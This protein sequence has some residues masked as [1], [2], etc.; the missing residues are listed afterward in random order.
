MYFL[1]AIIIF[2]TFWSCRQE[3]QLIDNNSKTKNVSFTH[4]K[5]SEFKSNVN[6]MSKINKIKSLASQ[7][8]YAKNSIEIYN[9]NINNAL[10]IEDTS[11]NSH[12]YIFKIP[13]DSYNIKN[14]VLSYNSSG[15]YDAYLV[16]YFLTAQERSLI[17]AGKNVD[18]KNKTSIISIDR[19][20]INITSKTAET[21]YELIQ[22]EEDCS[23][24]TTHAPTGCT[25]PDI[26]Y[27]L[28]EVP[29]SGGGSGTGDT[30]GNTSGP[31]DG[32]TSG[33]GSS[34][35][36]GGG[37]GPAILIAP[38]GDPIDTP[39]EMI[40]I[41]RDNDQFKKRM[42]TLKGKTN[43]KKET[44]YIQKW[45]GTYEY[46]DNATAT[47]DANSLTLPLVETNT[48]IKGFAHTHVDDYEFTDSDGD[49][50]IKIGIKELSPADVGYFMDLVKNAQN[51]GRP[52]KEV[53][54]VM[55]SSSV[56]YQIRFTGSEYQ[57][58]TFT[59]EQTDL[60]REPYKKLMEPYINKQDKLEFA[61][62]W[63]LSEKMNLKGITLYRMN[64]DGTNTEI[65][66]N[67]EKTKTIETKC[68]N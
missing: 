2:E 23:C 8:Q 58:K 5:L 63:Y 68:P 26:V 21:C 28:I 9:V 13:S 57:I 56:D 48:Y 54:G 61:F 67:S 40:K 36:T 37:S 51:F 53:Y 32:G 65:V 30:G 62:L 16:N 31:T 49:V 47:L 33:G 20:N 34:G 14:V 52:L 44:G 45:G 41:Q 10:Y 6:L 15:N 1:I 60:H 39:C 59:K 64:S 19:N 66:L 11:N 25:H 35:G 29:C 3:N 7:S 55:I 17:S 18:I 24:H 50:K 43:L 4:K 22:Y 42:D 27:E 46:K 38:D 12:S